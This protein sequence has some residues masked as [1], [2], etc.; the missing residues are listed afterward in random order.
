MPASRSTRRHPALLRTLANHPGIGFLLVRSERHGPVVL[1][2]GGAEHRLDTGEII[3]DATR[4]R[5]SARARRTPYGAPTA[6]RTCADIMVNSM[7]DPETGAVHAFEEQIGSHGGLGGE[8]N[9]PFL[10]SPVELS[11]ADRRTGNWS[12]PSRCTW[13]C[14]AG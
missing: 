3:G 7:Y 6:S 2:A 13:C 4:W 5:P 12:A 1:G 11:R 8:Q 14:A 9:Q 10:L